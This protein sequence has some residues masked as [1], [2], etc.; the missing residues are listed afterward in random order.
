MKKLNLFFIISFGACVSMYAQ[1]LLTNSDGLLTIDEGIPFTVQ[2]N[3]SNS[4]TIQNEGALRLYGNWMNSGDYR[5]VSGTFSLLGENQLFESGE[6]SY[7]NLEINSSGVAV[8]SDLSITKS[9]TL[10][11]GIVS[12]TTDTKITIEEGA[13][14]S[15]ASPNSY[16]DGALFTTSSG[17]FTFPIGSE[18]EFLPVDLT[19]IQSTEPVGIQAFSGGLDSDASSEIDSFSSNRYW[20]IFENDS[21]SSDGISLPVISEVFIETQEEAAIAFNQIISDPL[22][23]VGDSEL[24]GTLESGIISVN[25]PIIWGY[26]LLSDRSLSDPPIT[27]VNVVTSLQDGKHDFLRIENIEFYENNKVEIFDRQGNKVFEMSGYNNQ[28]KVFRGSANVGIGGMLATGSYYYT[29]QLTGS[30]REAG[31]IYVKN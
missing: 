3:I 19:N 23:I 11:S 15:G 10:T 7:R 31:F 27:V 26:Y 4:G 12:L 24:S 29:V 16:I 6:S 13:S 25:T 17:D 30:K 18:S 22:E 9:L 5:S 28:E 14:I 1:A 8:I 2:G 20:Q 21:F